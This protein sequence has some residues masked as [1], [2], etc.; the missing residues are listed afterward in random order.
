MVLDTGRQTGSPIDDLVPAGAGY[1]VL[2]EATTD[3]ASIAA[4]LAKWMPTAQDLANAQDEE[5]RNR[6]QI[7]TVHSPGDLLSVNG[8]YTLDNGA[9]TVALDAKLRE[10]GS[11]PVPNSLDLLVNVAH[12][13]SAMPGHKN[14]VWVT[15]DNALADWNKL[16]FNLDKGS[17]NIE[18]AALR[19][20]EAMN[21]AHVSVYPLDAS[22]L[23]ANVVSPEIGRN[24][25]VLTPTFQTNPIQSE[26]IKGTEIQAGQ[27]VNITGM[28]RDFGRA[29]H[30]DAQ[31]QQDMHSIQGVFR[32]VADATGGRAFRRSGNII[33]ELNDVVA[34]AHATYLLGFSPSQPADGKYHILTVKLVGHKDAALRFRSGYQYDQEPATMKERF[35][36][37]IWEP[38]DA[39]EIGVRTKIVSDATGNA[40]RV[41][42]AGSDLRLTQQDS[43]WA[44]KL[45]IFIVR[46]DQEALRAKITGLTVGLHLKPQTYQRAMKDGLTFDERL[47]GKQDGASLRVVVID[48]NTG[49]MGSV[50][51]PTA[52][53]LAQR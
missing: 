2:Q 9:Q 47:E 36:Q 39:S 20:Q 7:E 50:T 1:Q 45:D 32:E 22:R 12:H 31:A 26:L 48:V 34:D 52:A 49:R 10:M 38:V 41:T 30:L 33:G 27:D 11:R 21:K 29:G 14:L 24:N 3:H 15:S 8:N 16:S 43:I 53:L 5:K 44:G 6:Q 46:R 23:E 40:L 17:R 35:A 28:E 42:V 37:A 19:A 51:V 18:P 4:T 13:L 25:V